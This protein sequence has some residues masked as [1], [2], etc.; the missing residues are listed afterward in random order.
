[1]GNRK[2]EKEARGE[3]T[4]WA[5][6]GIGLLVFVTV[7]FG[8]LNVAGVI[9]GTIVER[10]VFEQSYQRQTGLEAKLATM[11]AQAA[12]LRVSLSDSDLTSSK[13][14]SLEAQLAAITVQIAA[15]NSQLNQ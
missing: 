11:E 13:R 12:E 2:I 8:V 4:R 14:A 9:G 5:F 10:E 1:M 6:W 7:V 3:A 15:T